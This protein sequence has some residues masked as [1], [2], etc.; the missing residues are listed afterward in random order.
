MNWLEIID[1][2]SV[3]NSLKLLEPE[4]KC[5]IEEL[6]KEAEYRAITV[7]NRNAVESDFSIH[8]YHD[9]DKI[10]SNGSHLGLHLVSVLKEFGLVN[11]SIW[12][13][14]YIK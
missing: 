14:R 10:H 8:L 12:V 13:E 7:Y 4:L 1:V 11:H 5:L 2:R 3:G 6:N 9:S